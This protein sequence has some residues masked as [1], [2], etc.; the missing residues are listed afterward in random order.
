[1]NI[2]DIFAQR[3]N[4]AMLALYPEAVGLASLVV[5]ATMEPPRDPAHG[6]LSTNLAMVCAKPLKSSPRDIA[7]KLS[8]Q[9]LLDEDIESVDVAGPGFLNLRLKNSVWQKVLPEILNDADAFGRPKAHTSEKVNVE[10]VS[11]NPTGPM[12]V[13][14]TRGAIFGDALA[15]LLDYCGYEV[16]REYYINDAGSQVDVLSRS[17][18]LRYREALGDTIGDIPAGL[19]PGDYLK[20][21]GQMLVKKYGEG[22]RQLSDNDAVD[23]I[24]AEVLDA[25][26]DLIRA[27]LKNLGVEH[28]VFFSEKTLH[29]EDGKI[30]ETLAWLREE[31]L[32][33]EGTLEPPKGKTPEDWENREQTLFRA[34]QFGDDTDRALVKS[35][36]SYTYFA[37]DIAYHRDKFLRGY[38]DQIIVLGADHAGYIK[39]LQ[40]AV[41]AVSGGAAQI[42]VKICQLVRLMR[43]GEPVKMSKRS[44]EL[45]TLAELVGEVGP[46]AARFLLLM[47]R[48]DASMDFDFSKVVEQT[49]ENPVFYVQYAHARACSVLRNATADLP[50]SDFSIENLKLADFSLLKTEADLTLIRAIAEWPRQINLATRAH[51]PHR[52][53]NYLHEL[54]GAFHAFYSKGNTQADLRFVNDNDP[55]MTVAR[56]AMA[57][58]LRGVLGSGLALL[59]VS[60]PDSLS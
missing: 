29:G 18:L 22:L 56:V 8:A 47:R 52:I 50:N 5:K 17:A 32:I 40:A 36:G 44:G 53:A 16:T 41:K 45:V 51:E 54:A 10:F 38:N 7:A 57:E 30:A 12:H 42:D 11:A 34:E 14:H 21:T 35:D 31:G 9:L 33:Y 46:D 39:R 3:A 24:K 4:K 55:K 1:M 13:G 37:A 43:N 20:S 6:D 49:R 60:A 58:S 59:G 23:K 48:N 25:M 2:F 27:D 28:D 26:L 15:A 19:Y